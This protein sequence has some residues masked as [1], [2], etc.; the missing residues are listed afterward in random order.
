MVWRVGGEVE[1][2]A[3]VLMGLGER[4]MLGHGLLLLLR[5]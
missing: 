5:G 1:G 4:G 3:G 2:E